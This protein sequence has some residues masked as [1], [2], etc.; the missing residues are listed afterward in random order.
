MST[1][2]PP[3]STL[4]VSPNPASS[5]ASA[6]RSR[7][8]IFYFLLT[9]LL[10][11]IVVKGFWPSYFGPMLSGSS[12]SRAWVM[13]LHGVIYTGWMLL[14]LLQVVLAATRRLAAHRKVGVFGIGYGIALWVI[15][16]VVTIAAP[17]MHV[18][19]GEWTIDRAAGFTLLPLVD[20]ILFGG[21]FAGAVVY[22]NRPEIHKRLIVAATVSVAFAAV[23]RMRIE[24]PALFYLTWVSPMLVGM[25]FDL[26]SRKRVH[27]V[28]WISMAAMSLAFVR[29]FFLESEA[30]LKIGRALLAPFV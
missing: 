3:A 12:A 10:I 8:R 26:W 14:L 6:A 17:V 15:G 11:G 20:M 9:L 16:L 7:S 4:E 29:V 28:Y 22:R 23:A 19:A 25:A 24:P 1:H 13:H 5:H 30:W 21:F 2:T 18:H 27:P